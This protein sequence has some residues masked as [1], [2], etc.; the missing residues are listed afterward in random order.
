MYAPGSDLED[1]IDAILYH[2]YTLLCLPLWII[3][4]CRKSRLAW[5]RRGAQLFLQLCLNNLFLKVKERNKILHTGDNKSLGVGPTTNFFVIFLIGVW[6]TT[7][8]F[9]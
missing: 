3:Q 2:R 7:N 1:T 4:T 5:E 6:P 9:F 8:D